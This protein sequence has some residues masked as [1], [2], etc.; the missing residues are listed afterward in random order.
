MSVGLLPN[1]YQGW[2]VNSEIHHEWV[3][4]TRMM[5]GLGSNIQAGPLLDQDGFRTGFQ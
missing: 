5:P 2:A 1:G 4:V 3:T